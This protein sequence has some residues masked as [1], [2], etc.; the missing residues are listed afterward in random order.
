MYIL[1]ICSL[2]DGYPVAASSCK[3]DAFKVQ[4][5]ASQDAAPLTVTKDADGAY[6]KTWSWGLDKSVDAAR[7]EQSSTA[8]AFSYAVAVTHDAGTVSGVSVSGTISVFNPNADAQGGALPVDITSVSDTLSDGTTCTVTG[9]GAQTLTATST[10]FAYTC[11]LGDT[12]PSGTLDNVVTVTWP[13]QFLADGSA[14]AAGKAD[15][16]FTGIAFDGTTVDD[17]ATVTDSYAGALGSVCSTDPSPKTFSYDRSVT[18]TAGT[19]TTYSNTATATTST[20][21]TEKTDI[22]DA[23]L[24]VGKD[25]TVSKTA[26]PSFTRT[27]GWGISKTVDKTLVKQVGGSA[28]FN[29]TVTAAQTGVT[30]SGW[31][32]TGTITVTNPN[33]WQDVTVDVTDAVDNGGTCTVSG[34]TSVVV[35]KSSSRDLTYSCT[36]ASAPTPASGTNTATATWDAAAAHTPKGAASGSAGVSFSTPTTTVNRTVTVTDAFNG[37]TAATLGT[38]TATDTAPFTSKAFAYSRTIAVPAYDCQ[39]YP[40]TAKITETGA[41]AAQTVKLC[42]PA[43]TGALTIGFWQNKN[44]QGIV[45]GGSSTSGVCN[46]ATWLRGYKPF[47]DLSATATCA[48]TATYVSNVVKAANASGATMN[49]MLKAQM[50]GTALDVYFSDPSLGGNKIGAYSG[51]G[52]AQKPIGAVVVDLTNVCKMVDSTTTGTATC[53]GVSANVSAAFGGATSLTVSQMLAYAASQSNAGGS[54]WYSQAKA[55]QEL[56]KNAFD[57]INNEKVFTA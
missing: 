14:L 28:T 57:A 23:T 40:N 25:L 20:T 32:A 21:G 6:T 24:C 50:L 36:W 19:C 18:G 48:Q 54:F 41:S 45:T 42:G 29:Y 31:A 47:Q 11:D 10:E 34:G 26:T 22:Q 8:G 9:G 17:C 5:G 16:R 13:D 44:G 7:K 43:R 39:S 46:S 30:D 55:T 12:L 53:G 1:A 56:A 33:D 15:F 38:A 3:Y 49:A 51:L 35:A 2:A 37:G 52:T 4:A 27:Y